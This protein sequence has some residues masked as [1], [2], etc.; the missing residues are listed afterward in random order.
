[1]KREGLK[2]ENIKERES[3]RGCKGCEEAGVAARH[4]RLCSGRFTRIN[5]HKIRLS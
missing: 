5:P 2:G 1:M 3:K 4:G